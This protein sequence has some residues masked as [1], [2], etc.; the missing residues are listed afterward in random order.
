M[1]RADD[2]ERLILSFAD[3]LDSTL[4]A[5][6][7]D[8]RERIIIMRARDSLKRYSGL[9]DVGRCRKVIQKLPYE[10]AAVGFPAELL[11][12]VRRSCERMTAVLRKV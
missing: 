6:G 4:D 3:K 2:V 5:S 1:P 7:G 12:T 10:L 9:H 11:T 8:I